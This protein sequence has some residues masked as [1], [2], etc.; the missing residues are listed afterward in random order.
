MNAQRQCDR[1]RGARAAARL[2]SAS[3]LAL[4]AHLSAYFFAFPL[5]FA[6]FAA[7]AF[8][9]FSAARASKIA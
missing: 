2:S 3:T 9:F 1:M 7:F 8:A 4:N 5:P 6:P